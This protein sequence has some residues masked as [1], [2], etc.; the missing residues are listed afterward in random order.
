MTTKDLIFGDDVR[1]KILEGV[2]KAS[3]AISCTLGPK[4]RNVILE[5]PGKPPRITKDGVSVAKEIHLEDPFEN[6]GAELVAEACDKTCKDAGDGTTTSSLL[7][8]HLIHEGMKAIQMG[9]NPVD[10]KR[11]MELAMKDVISY[12]KSY[13]TPISE[14]D[15]HGNLKSIATISA[16]GDEHIGSLLTEAFKTIGRDGSVILVEGKTPDTTLE[17]QHG[18]NL[19]FGYD[20]F[21]LNCITHPDTQTCEYK[22]AYIFFH[23]GDFTEEKI[24]CFIEVVKG[25]PQEQRLPI[26]VVIIAQSYK[27]NNVIPIINLNNARQNTRICPV[28]LPPLEDHAKSRKQQYDFLSDFCVITGAKMMEREQGDMFSKHI[29]TS[30][31]GK[32]ECVIVAR[33]KVTIIGGKG[34]SEAIESHKK[35]LIKELEDYKQRVDRDQDYER[36]LTTRIQHFSPM[37]LIRTGGSTTTEVSERKDRVEDAMHATKAAMD[38]GYVPGGGIALLRASDDL[39]IKAKNEDVEM[40]QKILKKAIRSPFIKILQ[41]AGYNADSCYEQISKPISVTVHAKDHK[42][43]D[44]DTVID[45]IKQLFTGVNADTG[46]VCHMIN[47]G[48][49][50]PTNVVISCVQNAVSIAGLLLTTETMISYHDRDPNPL[51][52]MKFK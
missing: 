29:D 14:E 13:S 33:N 50:D 38:G 8:Y 25:N 11:G 3:D 18:I 24:K 1:G 45:D 28:N 2:R 12:I 15:P 46:E 30:Y 17:F 4:G 7:T 42:G 6:M 47:E 10:L 49:I 31:F 26:P 48:I 19:D 39:I 51:T 44:V 27:G 34:E 22:D 43:K 20:A 40:G 9:T 23:D 5:I 35:N 52:N 32:A 21:A 16:N 41:N 36:H 37:A